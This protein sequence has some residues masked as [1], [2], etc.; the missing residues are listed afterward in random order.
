MLS[1]F[2][3]SCESEQLHLSGAIQPHGTLLLL[4]GQGRLSHVAANVEAFLGYKPEALL[5]RP[6]PDQLAALAVEVGDTPGS[7]RLNERTID[8]VHGPL[9]VVVIRGEQNRIILELTQHLATGVSQ[10][11]IWSMPE[12]LANDIL[13]AQEHLLRRIADLTGFQ[14][15]MFYSFH[16]DGDG[17]VVGEIRQG[18]A[19]GSYLGLRFP[20]SDIPQIARTLYLKNPW[21]LIPDATADSVPVLGR[22]AVIPDLTWSDLRSVSPIH[23]VYLANMGVR[24]SLSF[25]V[26]V[27]R[28][29]AALIAA[30]H[31]EVR[32][33]S[34]ALLEYAAMLVRNHAFALT[35]WHSQR[36]MRLLDGLNQHFDLIQGL[37]HRYG[38]IVDAWPESAVTLM[39]AF[40]ADGAILCLDGIQAHAGEGFEPPALAAFD[41]WF[42]YQQSDFVWIGDSLSRQVPDFPLSKIAGV[43]ALRLK[44]RDGSWLRIYLC[45]LE[46]V[47]E[48]TWGGNP[49]KPVEYHDAR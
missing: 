26:I 13:V 2:L 5:G 48:V 34:P 45:R 20:A 3:D 11:A 41:D 17:E 35:A 47:C 21:R 23:Q 24:A 10:P 12:P 36:R 7:R 6:L 1:R 15:V 29:L 38:N 43:A 44:S 28:S 40:Q 18:N 8:G 19:Y 46:H 49:D 30:H 9:D 33:L 16:N 31:S 32:H 4:D 27:G 25:P 37:L 42:C 14:R 22:E 39:E